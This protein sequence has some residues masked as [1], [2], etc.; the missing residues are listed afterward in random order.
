L[1]DS[2]E[3]RLGGESYAGTPVLFTRSTFLLFL[4]M[5]LIAAFVSFSRFTSSSSVSCSLM[6]RIRGIYLETPSV[7]RVFRRFRIALS[8]FFFFSICCSVSCL[9]VLA[10]NRLIYYSGIS[11]GRL[12]FNRRCC[13]VFSGRPYSTIRL[14]MSSLPRPIFSCE[15]FSS[16]P[17]QKSGNVSVNSSPIRPPQ[18]PIGSGIQAPILFYMCLIS[19]SSSMRVARF[20][21]VLLITWELVDRRTLLLR[22]STS[23][24]PLFD[25][26]LLDGVFIFEGCEDSYAI[27]LETIS[28]TRIIGYQRSISPVFLAFAIFAHGA[29]RPRIS[30]LRNLLI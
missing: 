16:G 13:L 6:N 15:V 26:G 25:I 18:S 24:P 7:F 9:V 17:Y 3:M 22:V 20:E 4:I 10:P 2:S 27:Y 14:L 8:I 21:C 19:H 30:P 28:P 23:V 5:F 29:R 12:I 11:S 1:F